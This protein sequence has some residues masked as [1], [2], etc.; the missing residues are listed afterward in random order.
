MRPAVFAALAAAGLAAC[1]GGEGTATIRLA[2][3]A[4]VEDCEDH[5]AASWRVRLHHGVGGPAT[6]YDRFGLACGETH[7]IEG[8]Q[9]GK[10]FA[11]WVEVQDADVEG[12]ALFEGWSD[13]V[14]VRVDE[15]VEVL[16]HLEPVAAPSVLSVA[17]EPVL[18]AA[19]STPLVVTGEGL[20]PGEGASGAQLGGVDLEVAEADDGTISVSV[21]AG[22]PGGDLVLT[23]CGMSTA[24]FPVR[25]LDPSP[26]EE[27]VTSGGC[28]GGE[29]LDAAALDD[30]SGVA[31]LLACPE[32]GEVVLRSIGAGSCAETDPVAVAGEP[33]AVAGA[34][35]GVWISVVD[36]G[37]GGR[38]LVAGDAA[39]A[40]D[41]SLPAPPVPRGL[42]ASDGDVL[43]LVEDAAAPAWRVSPE[44][45]VEPVP[46]LN[47]AGLL[48]DLAAGGG[49]V[50]A[51]TDAGA[52]LVLATPDA[53]AS[54]AVPTGCSDARAVAIGAA[55]AAVACA[56]P[57]GVVA[58][59]AG[60]SASLVPLDHA[61]L[62]LALDGRGDVAFALG[63]G[64]LSVLRLDGTEALHS[65]VVWPLGGAGLAAVASPDRLAVFGSGRDVALAF[66]YDPS[67]PCGGGP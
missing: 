11:I 16:V 8:L 62:D 53:A 43:V 12:G 65:I 56:D 9:P 35:G 40:P 26:G 32:G 34:A 42:A 66:A 59:P 49:R 67:L 55:S 52:L 6:G 14:T 60:G 24:A 1:A 57:P 21:P 41:V 10:T 2:L 7:A 13:E 38:L 64:A 27:V 29:V 25:V 3:G 45:E 48:R 30:G 17:P 31:V 33:R 44:G 18:A 15:D 36:E 51:I 19:G 23:G 37:G 20:R 50:A 4:A 58:V 63:S 54:A 46:A 5:C 28:A 39:D 47:V 61:A 22:A